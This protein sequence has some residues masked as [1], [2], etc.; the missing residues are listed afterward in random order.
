MQYQQQQM[1]A[2]PGGVQNV[3]NVTIQQQNNIPKPVPAMEPQCCCCMQVKCG[4]MVLT[5]L[6]VIDCIYS[7]NS[8]WGGIQ[9]VSAGG[10]AA[11]SYTYAARNSNMS[12]SK[13]QR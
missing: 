13:M 6:E 10:K 3:T 11:R 2:A 4:L 8:L 1:M 12:Y 5:V 7:L 9:I